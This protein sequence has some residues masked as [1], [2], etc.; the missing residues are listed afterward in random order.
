M[1]SNDPVFMCSLIHTSNKRKRLGYVNPNLINQIEL[2][3]QINENNLKYRNMRSKSKIAVKKN[4]H[5]DKRV[6]ATTYIG[7]T[8]LRWQHKACIMAPYNFK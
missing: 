3:P 6:V 7:R 2:N 4:S 8:M 5:N 1:K